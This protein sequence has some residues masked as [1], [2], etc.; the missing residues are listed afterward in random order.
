[1]K[2]N[3]LLQTLFIFRSNGYLAR[4]HLLVDQGYGS[5]I[6][7]DYGKI[8]KNDQIIMSATEAWESRE[9]G[10]DATSTKKVSSEIHRQIDDA[11]G[12]FGTA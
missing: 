4:T 6:E 1:L 8:M 9:L 12:R 7:V 10:A 2:P 5:Q 3:A 11:L